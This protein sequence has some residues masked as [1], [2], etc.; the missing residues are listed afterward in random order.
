MA[1]DSNGCC[2]NDELVDIYGMIT[3][4]PGGILWNDFSKVHV[5]SAL[6]NGLV[7]GVCSLQTGFFSGLPGWQLLSQRCS[8]C[9][10]WFSLAKL[11]S[12]CFLMVF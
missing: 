10:L 5:I 12:D 2:C 3:G 4:E 1:L 11:L 6:G 9:V 8:G 7:T